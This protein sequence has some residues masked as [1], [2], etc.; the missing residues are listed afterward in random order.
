MQNPIRL[1]TSTFRKNRRCAF[2][3]IREPLDH[4]SLIHACR[5]VIDDL[6]LPAY[7]IRSDGTVVIMG[8]G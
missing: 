2:D 5:A 6:P 7:T 1:L 3:Y 8:D 4:P